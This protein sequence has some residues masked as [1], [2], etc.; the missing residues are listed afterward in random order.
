[1]PVWHT[2]LYNAVYINNILK[3]HAWI[4][5]CNAVNITCS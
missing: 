2:W 5:G 3:K 1:V 4:I